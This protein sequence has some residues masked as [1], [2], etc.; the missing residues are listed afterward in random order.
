MAVERHSYET[1]LSVLMKLHVQAIH[2]KNGPLAH[3]ILSIA[4]SVK[5]ARSAEH[6][7]PLESPEEAYQRGLRDAQT[8][9][10]NLNVPKKGYRDMIKNVAEAIKFFA[11]S[12]L[13]PT[14]FIHQ[15]KI[16][17]DC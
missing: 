14:R 15:L 3:I 8:V 4:E 10:Q 5:H 16:P 9:I 12:N 2:D 11:K 6:N 13:P 1:Q 7:T 17:H